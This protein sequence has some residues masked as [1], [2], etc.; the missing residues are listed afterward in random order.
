MA[1]GG[2]DSRLKR[3][4]GHLGPDRRGGGWNEGAGVREAKAG[5]MP[6]LFQR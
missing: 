6:P 2:G 1:G 4:M 5:W 3:P